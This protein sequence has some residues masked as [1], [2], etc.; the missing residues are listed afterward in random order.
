M[1][2]KLKGFTLVEMIVVI[3]II[4]ILTG[5]LVPSASYFIRNAK[6]KTSNAEAKVVFNAALTVSQE[7]EAK[8]IT[9]LNVSNGNPS[10]SGLPSSINFYGNSVDA[11]V[12][13]PNGAG[14]IAADSTTPVATEFIRRVNEKVK[15]D[16]SEKAVWAVKYEANGAFPKLTAACYAS[17]D[18]DRYVGCYPVP[19]ESTEAGSYYMALNGVTN[20]ET[21]LTRAK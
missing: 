3:S 5:V 8:N 7:Y 4:A 13:Y 17:T 15:T 10:V 11:G 12:I 21:W 14:G 20:T 9:M 6:L 19:T 2:N 16:S 1:K 18:T